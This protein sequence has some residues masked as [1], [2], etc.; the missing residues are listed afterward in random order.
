MEELKNNNLDD[1]KVQE[2]LVGTPIKM[3][4]KSS[5]RSENYVGKYEGKIKH[6]QYKNAISV[7]LQEKPEGVPESVLTVIHSDGH[8][9]LAEQTI[10]GEHLK[11]S[12]NL[13]VRVPLIERTRNEL[14]DILSR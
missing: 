4:V 2:R 5:D 14:I 7:E 11:I 8:L 9:W 1:D 13:D 6:I 3:K 10:D 12:D